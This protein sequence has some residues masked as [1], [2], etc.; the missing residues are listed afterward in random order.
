MIRRLSPCLAAAVTTL[1]ILAHPDLASA[2]TKAGVT[3]PD[4]LQ[5]DGTTLVLNGM[6]VRAFTLLHINGYVGALYLPQKT[7]DAGAALSEKGPKALFMQFLRGAAVDRVH[8]MYLASSRLYC[9]KHVCTDGDKVAFEKLLGTVRPV[10]PGD[11]TGFIVTDSGVQV[12]FNGAQVTKIDDP[13]F[14]RTILD[15]DLGTTPPS[16]ELRDGLLGK[17]SS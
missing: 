9:S 11:R 16:E 7:S 1:T 5:V 13:A 17:S 15:S 8:Q 14:G 6:G 4:T 12:L 10:Q 3:M 2:G